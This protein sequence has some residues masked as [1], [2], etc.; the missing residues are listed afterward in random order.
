[1]S[2]NFWQDFSND[3]EILTDKKMLGL[4]EV[5]KIDN[6][7]QADDLVLEKLL[8]NTYIPTESDA[9]RHTVK[10]DEGS[11]DAEQV[12]TE[13]SVATRDDTENESDSHDGVVPEG[14]SQYPWKGNP[15]EDED[16]QSN[17]KSKPTSVGV[18]SI[19]DSFKKKFGKNINDTSSEAQKNTQR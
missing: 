18:G 10:L 6:A 12:S 8:G 15:Y 2:Q 4:N 9:K 11:T 17:K 14:Q 1:M 7:V 5:E 16:V 3:I 19:L 13:H